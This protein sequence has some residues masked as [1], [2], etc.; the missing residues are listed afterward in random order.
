MIAARTRTAFIQYATG[1]HELALATSDDVPTKAPPGAFAVTTKARLLV[2][3]GKIDAAIERA[4][5]ASRSILACHRHKLTLGRVL[6]VGSELDGPRRAFRDALDRSVRARGSACCV[7]RRRTAALHSRGEMPRFGSIRKRAAA[8]NNLGWLYV[9][10]AESR[11]GPGARPDREVKKKPNR[12][13]S[14][15][16]PRRSTSRLASNEIGAGCSS[17]RSVSTPTS[18]R[19]RKRGALQDA[20]PVYIESKKALAAVR[21]SG[22]GRQESNAA[23]D[24]GFW[25]KCSSTAAPRSVGRLCW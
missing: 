9:G 4:R 22:H 11:G 8:A 24:V 10:G 16:G 18:M 15:R 23:V 20:P 1:N 5:Q 19:P 12:P 21:R 3:E 25:R 7:T 6:G 14:D 13:G 17:R 2:A